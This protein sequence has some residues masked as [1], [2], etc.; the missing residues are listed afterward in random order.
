MTYLNK[1]DI[2][3]NNLIISKD[4]LWQFI[5]KVT[6]VLVVDI[7]DNSILFANPNSIKELRIIEQDNELQLADVI[8][9]KFKLII[10]YGEKNQFVLRTWDNREA[11]IEITSS[12]VSWRGSP[13]YFLTL[14]SFV[15]M[16]NNCI[17]IKESL[18]NSP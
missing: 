17:K 2:I 18:F 11:L 5:N 10:T 3:P 12:I 15:S 1:I 8:G 9:R 4:S 14:S 6:S 7:N 13:A 16:C